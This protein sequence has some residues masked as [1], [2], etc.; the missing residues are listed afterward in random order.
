MNQ[1]INASFQSCVPDFLT[2]LRVER[3][4]SP[5]TIA[6]YQ[7]D[8][9]ALAAFL[10]DEGCPDLPPQGLDH[11]LLRKWLGTL[12]DHQAPASLARK[13]ACVRSFLRFLIRRG[14]LETSPAALVSSPKLPRKHRQFFS[15][16][17]VFQLLDP[18]AN[19]TPLTLRD[20]AAF[21]LI[22]SAGLRV[23]EAI[24]ANLLDLDLVEGWIRVTGKGA[25]ERDVP[26]GA[27][28]LLALERYLVEARPHLADANGLQDPDA[29]FL[30]HRGGRITTRS[31]HRLLK[32]RQLALG[33]PADVS[34]H[35]LRHAFATH[36][37]D[38]GADL[39]AIQDMLG[40]ESLSTTARYTHNSLGRLMEV[41]DRAHPR[42]QRK[43][44]PPAPPQ[45][46]PAAEPDADS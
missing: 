10:A 23:S 6:A 44:R 33:M 26:V 13:V 2:Y 18:P 36:L 5:N 22:Y 12:Y 28:A 40:H 19:P 25:K 32:A 31:I 4:A 41:Y 15:V 8:L 3:G 29:I 21:E 11:L 9:H 14:R 39:R 42:A 27:R 45:P 30:N 38:S 24:G 1:D 17:E 7:S 16:E 34:P 37:L 20:L 46:S 43:P 35:G